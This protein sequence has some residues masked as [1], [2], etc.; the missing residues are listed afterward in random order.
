MDLVKE[1]EN[2]DGEIEVE[3]CLEPSQIFNPTI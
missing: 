2:S 1:V 3:E